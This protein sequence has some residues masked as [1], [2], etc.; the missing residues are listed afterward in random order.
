[1]E[2]HSVCKE[3]HSSCTWKVYASWSCITC[4]HYW[5]V[6]AFNINCVFSDDIVESR[7]ESK[8]PFFPVGN[9]RSKKITVSLM[10]ETFMQHVHK[11][12]TRLG[13]VC[14]L[15]KQFPILQLLHQM[16]LSLFLHQLNFPLLSIENIHF[17]GWRLDWCWQASHSA[18][19]FGWY[20]KLLCLSQRLKLWSAPWV[21]IF[22]LCWYITFL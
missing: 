22:T 16:K 8:C 5:T 3:K 17:Q 9:R 10:G 14:E 1:M 2:W 18:K 13:T 6:V 12:C 4:A 20:L 21:V 11:P 19:E 7:Y 15:W